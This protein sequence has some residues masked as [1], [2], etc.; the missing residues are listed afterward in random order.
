MD[1]MEIKIKIIDSEN[2][3]QVKL[4]INGQTSYAGLVHAISMFLI[5]VK[6]FTDLAL[7]TDG[8]EDFCERLG[9]DDEE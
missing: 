7:V 2:N 5:K 1:K 3:T 8:I 6:D 4:S 9:K